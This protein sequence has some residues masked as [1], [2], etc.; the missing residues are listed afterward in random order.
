MISPSRGPKCCAPVA[1]TPV[2]FWMKTP[3]RVGSRSKWSRPCQ[4]AHAKVGNSGQA[5]RLSASTRHS[6]CYPSPPAQAAS[7]SSLQCRP[8]F[9]LSLFLS[10]LRRCSSPA[11]DSSPMSPHPELDL[12]RVVLVSPRNPL[13]IGA[14]ARAISNFGF[15]HLRVVNP[16]HMAFRKALSA[17]CDALLLSRA[18]EFKS[19]AEAVEDCT[20]VVGT[21]SVGQRPM[22]HP[23]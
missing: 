18:E 6:L 9:D 23:T 17:F 11:V 5:G 22:Q 2:T 3:D 8:P 14:A 1:A 20:L 21:T 16:Y 19:L 4:Q 12:L 15:L 7:C 13:N 10:S